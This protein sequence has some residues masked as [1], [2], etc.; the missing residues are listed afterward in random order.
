MNEDDEGMDVLR[1]GMGGRRGAQERAARCGRGG[2]DGERKLAKQ[3]GARAS[4]PMGRNE[5]LDSRKAIS[6]VEQSRGGMTDIGT[7]G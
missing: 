7:W 3:E 5:T 6:K 4:L 1:S 2:P